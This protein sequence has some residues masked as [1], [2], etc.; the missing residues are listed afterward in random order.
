M[1]RVIGVLLSDRIFADFSHL[2]FAELAL[3]FKEL[4]DVAQ[5][6]SVQVAEEV[7]HINDDIVLVNKPVVLAV[8][9]DNL[10]AIRSEYCNNI[11]EH[12]RCWCL[13]AFGTNQALNQFCR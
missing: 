12:S 5:I 7:A 8:L 2:S 6:R 11:Q 9:I 4:F 10:E 13:P 1:Q 3:T